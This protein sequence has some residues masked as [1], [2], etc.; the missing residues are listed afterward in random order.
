MNLVS[1]QQAMDIFLYGLGGYENSEWVYIMP[2]KP[3][4]PIA[5]RSE[6]LTHR[7]EV[8]KRLHPTT[9]ADIRRGHAHYSAPYL[10]EIHPSHY[11]RL[12]L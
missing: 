1:L 7:F 11:A 10:D 3:S 4:R 8:A 5:K 2:Y 9:Q 12:G 6:L